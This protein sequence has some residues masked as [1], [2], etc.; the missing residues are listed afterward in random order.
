ML[1]ERVVA[2][3]CQRYGG[4]LRRHLPAHRA[5]SRLRCCSRL[6]ATPLPSSGAP[7]GVARLANPRGR[8][9]G[10]LGGAN[11]VARG[12]SHVRPSEFVE[13]Q[14]AFSDGPPELD[15]FI[16]TLRHIRTRRSITVDRRP[17]TQ[18][19]SGT[20]FIAAVA[21]TV[22]PV[23]TSHSKRRRLVLFVG[24]AGLAAVLLS[25]GVVL[26][27]ER[28]GMTTDP[29]VVISAFTGLIALTVAAWQLILLVPPPPAAFLNAVE[30]LDNAAAKLA[31]NVVAQWE[32]EARQRSLR[33][34]SPLQVPWAT[35]QRPVAVPAKDLMR[36]GRT[37][38]S[39]QTGR[40]NDALSL[41]DH[42]TDNQLVILGDPGAGKSVLAILFTLG[43]LNRRLAA[44]P[45]P[46][47]LPALSWD[48]ASI[49]LEDWIAY[50]LGIDYPVLRDV[51]LFGAN[52]PE[53]LV[54]E[55]RIVAVLDG[56]DEM[57]IEARP[58]AI[59][60]ISRGWTERPLIVTCRT[61]EFERAVEQGGPVAS[62]TVIELEPIP[63]AESVAY[64]RDGEDTTRRKRWSGVAIALQGGRDLPL[65]EALAT[66]L[67]VSLA[68]VVYRDHDPNE[69][70]DRIA[71]PDSEAIEDRL[72]DAFLPIA[73]GSHISMALTTV[74]ATRSR[75]TWNETDA[76]RWLTFLARDLNSRKTR[77]IAWWEFYRSVPSKAGRIAFVV[78]IALLGGILAGSLT[79][80]DGLSAPVGV[81]VSLAVAA[82]TGLTAGM[83]AYFGSI[84]D[85]PVH[86]G[87]HLGLG[88]YSG[89]R[90]EA[91]RFFLAGAIAPAIGV[92]SLTWFSSDVFWGILAG[93]ICGVVGS[94]V[95]GTVRW[96]RRIA[97]TTAP[98]PGAVLQADRRTTV[99]HWV[100]AG[101][102]LG[103]AVGLIFLQQHGIAV[104]LLVALLT[105][106]PSGWAVSSGTA[107]AWFVM[108]RLWLGLRGRLPLRAMAF[109]D[110]AHRR[111][112]LRQ[113]GAVYQFRH[114]R[115]QDHLAEES[116]P[117]P[118]ASATQS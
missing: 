103:G 39:R 24:L 87:V 81:L 72:L 28:V 111:G 38:I 115:L 105:A 1:C 89:T 47:L 20:M 88:G 68:K 104:A 48:P 33:T 58:L 79:A 61:A 77:D 2:V 85:L 34:P 49:N 22:I 113:F 65:V 83:P 23:A 94:L 93:G 25:L 19:L 21:A 56:L 76:R 117:T 17:V 12:D 3:G 40:L 106:V 18:L 100:G 98:T 7:T 55:G 36:R 91:L 66:P 6:T 107:Y 30:Q 82:T 99:I 37:T 51:T 4:T 80:V 29:L 15:E 86:F 78:H 63:V 73:Y 118:R 90:N 54:V 96:S 109:L 16:R 74:A 108:T 69:I 92:G 35:T 13:L 112:V 32:R 43:L 53:R 75:R 114:G 5:S 52:A 110:D 70:L 59:A 97:W 11:L 8:E 10:H 27:Q 64:L 67:M 45:V 62:A 41:F 116:R 50:R 26:H 46:V 31:E 57:P 95:I 71:L 60:E 9:R 84:P 101:I 14:N 102:P 42:R 44:D